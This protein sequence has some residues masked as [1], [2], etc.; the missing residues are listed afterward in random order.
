MNELIPDRHPVSVGCRCSFLLSKRFFLAWQ[1]VAKCV[2]RAIGLRPNPNRSFF[3]KI[4]KAWKN[5]FNKAKKYFQQSENSVWIY[6]NCST[7]PSVLEY[8]RLSTAIL[9]CQ[10]WTLAILDFPI[11][12]C[13]IVRTDIVFAYDNPGVIGYD[14]PD[15]WPCQDKNE[16]VLLTRILP[17]A[18]DFVRC[19]CDRHPTD[20]GCR[21]L[22]C[23]VL[24]SYKE[25]PIPWKNKESPPQKIGWNRDSI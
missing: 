6:P 10:Y 8:L 7:S 22:L 5:I 1:G 21:S 2:F 14:L 23:Y 18:C 24:R 3:Q 11:V 13:K 4:S 12:W 9:V 17:I 19:I 25:L 20:T 15:S 16:T